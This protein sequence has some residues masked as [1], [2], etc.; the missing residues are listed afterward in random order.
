MPPWV[1]SGADVA[2]QRAHP[3]SEP[4]TLVLQAATASRSAVVGERTPVCLA[5][6]KPPLAQHPHPGGEVVGKSP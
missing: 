2:S 1:A 3:G 5:Y 4:R 6:S